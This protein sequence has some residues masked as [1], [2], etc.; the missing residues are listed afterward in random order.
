VRRAGLISVAWAALLATSALPLSAQT[1]NPR[2]GDPCAINLRVEAIVNL[3]ASGQIITGSTAK[4]IYICHL[5]LVTGAAQNVAL[6]EGTGSTCGTNTVG[7]AGG[8]TAAAGWNLAINQAVVEGDGISWVLAT[9]TAADNVCL[10]SSSTGQIS[11]VV[12][13]V[14]E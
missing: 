4:H 5:A 10:L 9:A 7:M 8:N 3:A 11:G 1:Y 2:L 14:Q 12:Q 13:Y 6:V